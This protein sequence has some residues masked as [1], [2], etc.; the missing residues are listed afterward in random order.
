M[1]LGGESSRNSYENNNSCRRDRQPALADVQEG[2]AET[3]LRY[4]QQ[5]ADDP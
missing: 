3:I 4:N 5:A 1:L 2:K